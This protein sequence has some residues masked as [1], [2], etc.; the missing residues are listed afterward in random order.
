MAAPRE[1]HCR[2]GTELCAGDMAMTHCT[3]GTTSSSVV[4]DG[5][6]REGVGSEFVRRR[7]FLTAAR[8][9]PVT[10]FFANYYFAIYRSTTRQNCNRNDNM[11]H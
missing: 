3:N 7:Q 9:N 11:M 5:Q 10:A 2:A 4:R 8:A 1:L 6:D